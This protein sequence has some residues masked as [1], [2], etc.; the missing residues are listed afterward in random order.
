MQIKQTLLA[1]LDAIARSLEASGHAEAL[2]GLG[3]VG[4]ELDRL[5]EYSDLDF[6]AIVNPALAGRIRE[7]ARE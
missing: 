4:L 5:D 6:F 1:R 7:L 2:I 3:S